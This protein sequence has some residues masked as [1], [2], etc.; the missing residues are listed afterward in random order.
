MHVFGLPSVS[1]TFLVADPSWV[2][3]I[4]MVP[5]ILDHISLDCPD[6]KYLYPKLKICISELILD[7]YEYIPVACVTMHCMI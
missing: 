1:Q 4:T 6:H 3:E 2:Q 5:Y 7:S